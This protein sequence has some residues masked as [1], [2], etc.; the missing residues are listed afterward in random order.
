MQDY[1]DYE[2]IA[3]LIEKTRH[4]DKE[5]FKHILVIYSDMLHSIIHSFDAPGCDH[6]DLYQEAQ[7][8]LYKAVMTFDSRYS[9]FSTYAY[10]CIKSSVLSFL[11]KY[12]A[13]G[14]IPPGLIYSLS[15]ED[16]DVISIFDN[17]ENEIIDR[18]SLEMLVEK[19]NGLLSPLEKKV[20]SLYLSDTS[21]ANI[22]KL[23]GKTE[24]AVDNAIQ[25]IRRKLRTLV[26]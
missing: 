1:R 23:S 11:R 25:R 17:P 8:G 12:S 20:L 6:D 16:F 24:K 5:A 18:E 15:D 2:N 3:A 14:T 7:M 19:I 21:Y 22:A 9:S 4:T 10:V 26:D 13:K